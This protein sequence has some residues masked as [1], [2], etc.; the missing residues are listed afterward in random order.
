MKAPRLFFL[1]VGFNLKSLSV[2][3]WFQLL[4]LLGL[5]AMFSVVFSL[6][7]GGIGSFQANIGP[8]FPL[9]YSV[10]VGVIFFSGEAAGGWQK[11]L[12]L[13]P[14]AEFLLARPF[15]RRQIHLIRV[16]LYFAVMLAAPLLNLALA[17]QRPN[18][19]FSFYKSKTQPTEV[20][21]KF[22]T[23]QKAFPG[24][25]MVTGES[26][27]HEKLVI[28]GGN[29]RLAAWQL[30]MTMGIALGIQAVVALRPSTGLQVALMIGFIAT[31]A[32]LAIPSLKNSWLENLFLG[33]VRHGG[34]AFL[35]TRAA[36]YLVQVFVWK[37]VQRMEPE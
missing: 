28:P 15:S 13:F 25:F 18:L 3:L 23:Y 2:V 37:R 1:L 31:M 32:G 5:S 22:S 4:I 12:G 16:V 9:F 33:F 8:T 10:V 30:L 34:L 36:F 6:G 21:D 35:F 7:S 24:S 20:A 26:A 11:P 14:H 19:E 27:S 29:Q 17:S